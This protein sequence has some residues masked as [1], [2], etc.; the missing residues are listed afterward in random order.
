MLYVIASLV[1]VILALVVVVVVLLRRTRRA[2]LGLDEI[3][4]DSLKALYSLSREKPTVRPNDLARAAREPRTP[5]DPALDPES[6]PTKDKPWPDKSRRAEP[7]E[8]SGYVALF[9]AIGLY[10]SVFKFSAYY[11]AMAGAFI[12]LVGWFWPRRRAEVRP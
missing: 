2:V 10:G 4:E 12:G 11:V 1:G 5:L 9:S 6:R 8:G 7:Q 3:A